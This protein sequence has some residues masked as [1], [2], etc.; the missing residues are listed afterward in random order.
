[1][2]DKVS[3]VSLADTFFEEGELCGF[4]CSDDALDLVWGK[5]INKA[6]YYKNVYAVK[7]WI[8][9]DISDGDDKFQL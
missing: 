4:G 3:L 9:Y 7:N 6:G 1:M 8:W 5:V 2:N